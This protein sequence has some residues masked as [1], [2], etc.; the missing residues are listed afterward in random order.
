MKITTR[1][2]ISIL[3]N[4]AMSSSIGFL[5]YTVMGIS[6]SIFALIF[7]AMFVWPTATRILSDNPF[8]LIGKW[9]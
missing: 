9:L 6:G 7:S 1:G 5:S 3:Y 4:M 2:F 8:N